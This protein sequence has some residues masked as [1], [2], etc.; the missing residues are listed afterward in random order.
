MLVTESEAL[1]KNI[2]APHIFSD[3]GTGAVNRPAD[4]SKEDTEILSSVWQRKEEFQV[5]L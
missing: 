1:T 3:C 5:S 2:L 4:G